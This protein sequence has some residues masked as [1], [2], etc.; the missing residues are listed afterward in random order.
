M[1]SIAI[2]HVAVL[3]ALASAL[4]VALSQ[5]KKTDIKQTEQATR[6]VAT[7]LESDDADPNRLA[8]V[9]KQGQLAIPSLIAALERGPSPAKRE[10]V[11]RSLEADYD[12]LAERAGARRLRS[13]PDFIGHYLA[14]FEAL[15]R[16]RA[17]Q[18]LAAIG[19]TDARNVLQ[20][21]IDKTPR[22]E[23]RRAIQLA[24]KDVK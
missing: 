22:D 8:N 4:P 19:S 24:L 1:A 17:A 23:V 18:A 12:A 5:P 2:R 10:L 13:K 6:A 20:A 21:A 9:R 11:R 14:N 7:W 3:A 16:I 15:Y